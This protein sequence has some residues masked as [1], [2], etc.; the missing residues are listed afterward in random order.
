MSFRGKFRN[1]F[2]EKQ[3]QTRNGAKETNGP[4]EACRLNS[5][6]RNPSESTDRQELHCP[7]LSNL[8]FVTFEGWL[9]A[10]YTENLVGFP[11]PFH[12]CVRVADAC[13][14]NFLWPPPASGVPAV[15]LDELDDRCAV[16]SLEQRERLKV[17]GG[18]VTN[19]RWSVA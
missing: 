5:R 9:L 11:S 4:G 8:G 16:S 17:L 6:R 15:L 14:R 3:K 13:P 2:R 7:N 12:Q 18:G 19:T 1:E 10:M